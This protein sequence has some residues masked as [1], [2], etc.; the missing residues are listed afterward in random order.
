MS[1]NLI[2]KYAMVARGNIPL[3]EYPLEQTEIHNKA[4]KFIGKI[5]PSSPHSVME[6]NNLIFTA[7]SENDGLTFVCCCDKNVETKDVGLFLNNLKSQ[8]I[9]AYG[10]S[11]SS[12]L[13]NEKNEEFGAPIR[14]LLSHFNEK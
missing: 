11:S 9:Q 2:F 13:P 1:E 12:I 7:Y 5:D 14:D 10:A 8:W 3:A 6:Q 4:M